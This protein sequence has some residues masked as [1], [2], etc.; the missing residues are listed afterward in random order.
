M[1][2]EEVGSAMVCQESAQEVEE[3]PKRRGAHE[4]KGITLFVKENDSKED[5]LAVVELPDGVYEVHV[6]NLEER[7]RIRAYEED[8]QAYFEAYILMNKM[9]GKELDP[10]H[11]NSEKMTFDKSDEKE[12]SSWI[13]KK[14]VKR[15][16]EEAA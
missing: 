7:Q 6:E 3:H 16:T 5:G 4:W 2:S 9:N 10:R 1:L 14:V 13:K 11:F 12:W 8:D 15:L